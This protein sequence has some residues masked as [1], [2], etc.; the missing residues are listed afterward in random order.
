MEEADGFLIERGFVSV[1]SRGPVVTEA[2]AA[3]CRQVEDATNAEFADILRTIDDQVSTTLLAGFR[4]L[5]G[6][7]PRPE[8]DR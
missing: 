6:E 8:L 1:D 7:D 3:A 4:G 2:G 5:P